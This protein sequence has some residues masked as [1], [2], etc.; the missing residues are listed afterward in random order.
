[1]AILNYEFAVVGA[2][3]VERSFASIEKRAAIHNARMNRMFGIRGTA[4]NALRTARGADPVAAATREKIS[5]E[6]ALQREKAKTARIELADQRRIARE[7]ERSERQHSLM[8]RQHHAYQLKQIDQQ[9]RRAQRAAVVERH[10]RERTAK[11][12]VGAV[13]RGAGGTLKAVGALGVGAL[14][15]GGTFA[16]SN[17][18]QNQMSEGAQ[19]SKL[20]NQAGRPELK[21]QLLK[22]SRG[23]R[24]FT[25][26]EALAGMSTFV[27]KTG[28]LDSARLIIKD[29]GE[30]ALATDANLGDLGATAGQA[31]NVLKDQ[32]SD[33][34][35]RMKELKAIMGVLAQ[36]GAMGAVEISDL[37]RDFGKLGAATRAFEGNAPDLLRA[38][39]AFAQVAV[40]KG[41]AEGSADASTAATRMAS[42][43]VTNSKKFKALGVNIK[44][45]NDPT[46]L[47][48]PMEIMADVLDKTKGD[49][50]K[51][52]GLFGQESAKIFRGFAAT[53]SEAEKKQKG[54]G[55]AAVMA[56][57]DRYAKATLDP[58]QLKRQADSRM[59]DDDLQW[60]EQMKQL[61]NEIG[62]HLL[63]EV[64]KLVPELAK[65]TPEIGKLAGVAAKVLGWFADNPVRGVGAMIGA[66]I[67]TDLAK[68]AIGDA[69]RKAM[70]AQMGGG[71]V[72]VPGGAPIP[73][74]TG[75]G[76]AKGAMAAAGMMGVYGVAA[77]GAVDLVTDVA[78]SDNKKKTIADRLRF[79]MDGK[80]S[81]MAESL[82]SIGP[83]GSIGNAIGL[84]RTTAN[85]LDHEGAD[86]GNIWTDVGDELSAIKGK[87]SSW[88]GDDAPEAPATNQHAPAAQAA[89]ASQ[90]TNSAAEKLENAA[91]AIE[92]AAVKL[93]TTTVN[94]GNS[95]SP[96]KD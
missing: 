86:G 21:A 72:P 90:A 49:I 63:P 30:L 87:V 65:L 58:A 38:V 9:K 69:V 88:F 62:T 34:V 54:G 24:G 35:E 83:L 79:G 80:T 22:E 42:D 76:G 78:S 60:K 94:R 26:G 40:A 28:D 12:F 74:A 75:K 16:V 91:G 64:R 45:K 32:I 52:S 51:T 55:R 11:G 3:A 85:I 44:S 77:T 18:I 37:A 66:A 2:D 1:M 8:K 59:A 13:G 29:L 20:A 43:M 15:V 7:V 70:V 19:A 6:K 47:R 5:R 56:E 31:F 46:K 84:G 57:F 95:P 17:A 25:G 73:G 41:G 27:T 71:S 23:V 53:Y 10:E 89:Q 4:P 39:G 14:A 82:L 93:G 96:V 48:N 61:E 36:Q 81:R 67:V 68:A 92:R 50:S 33:P